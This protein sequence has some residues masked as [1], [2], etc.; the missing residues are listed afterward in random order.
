[1]KKYN[2]VEILSIVKDLF[3]FIYGDTK[4]FTTLR[5]KFKLSVES[6]KVKDGKVTEL[7]FANVGTNVIQSELDV[8]IESLKPYAA[9]SIKKQNEFDSILSGTG[10]PGEQLKNSGPKN[11]KVKKG[12]DG[13]TKKIVKDS[14]LPKENKKDNSGSVKKPVK[15]KSAKTVKKV[16]SGAKESKDSNEVN[17]FD[18]LIIQ[19]IES[20]DGT[21]LKNLIKT[22]LDAFAGDSKLNTTMNNWVSK[23][24]ND[25]DAAIGM[26]T[27]AYKRKPKNSKMQVLYKQFINWLEKPIGKKAEDTQETIAPTAVTPESDQDIKSVPLSTSNVLDGVS[28]T[29]DE[30]S[31]ETDSKQTV[32]YLSGVFALVT[33]DDKS[34]IKFSPTL[35]QKTIDFLK[36]YSEDINNVEFELNGITLNDLFKEYLNI[37]E[38][39]ESNNDE[40]SFES[41]LLSDNILNCFNS[42]YLNNIQF[43]IRKMSGLFNS[44]VLRNNISDK[45]HKV[46]NVP[47]H[48]LAR[49]TFD[50][51]QTEAYVYTRKIVNILLKEAVESNDANILVNY[52][53]IFGEIILRSCCFMEDLKSNVK[54]LDDTLYQGKNET[55]NVILYNITSSEISFVFRN[56]TFNISKIDPKYKEIYSAVTSNNFE[57]LDKLVVTVKSIQE[58]LTKTI[59]DFNSSDLNLSLHEYDQDEDIDIKI[60]DKNII[61]N[62]RIY[63]GALSREFIQ[64]TS[65]M[66]KEKLNKFKAFIKNC[67]MNP[68]HESVDQLYDFVVSNNLQVTPSGTV[69]L[70]KWVRD[71]YYEMDMLLDLLKIKHR[72]FVWKQLNELG[73]LLNGLKIKLKK[74]V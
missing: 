45:I 1:M 56:S 54:L 69:L 20:L 10:I 24:N 34:V 36:L 7:V 22:T 44:P 61:F 30:T 8:A 50:M 21:E 46:F 29:S 39:I 12:T 19:F 51:T 38:A 60:V 74:F 23:T 37:Y 71:D 41:V 59:K 64:Y 14:S 52:N 68:K 33:F 53:N 11:I 26:F 9:R 32:T 6:F 4:R 25:K 5:N 43:A 62:N 72:K 2:G 70:Y 65:S 40:L 15:D 3:N 63:K 42:T 66:D 35:N 58:N 16:V 47:T 73:M 28:P 55:E 67:N 13:K 17:Q 18:K 31:D 27:S 48:D 57:E 49:A